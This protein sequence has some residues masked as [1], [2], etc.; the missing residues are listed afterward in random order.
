MER[1]WL[2]NY[3]PGVPAEIDWKQ[4]RSLGELFERC[5]EQFAAKPAYFNMGRALSFGDLDAMTRNAGAW[6]QS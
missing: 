6:L 1:L 4:Y 5:A 3:P 2:K